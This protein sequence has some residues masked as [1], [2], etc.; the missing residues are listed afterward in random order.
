MNYGVIFAGGVGRRMQSGGIPKQFLTIDGIPIIVHTLQVFQD[1]NQID[2]INIAGLGGQ[3][4]DQLI[5]LVKQYNL[6][7]V[8]KIVTGGETGQMSIYNALMATK[9][10]SKTDKDIA[11]IHDGVRPIIDTKLLEENIENVKKYGTSISCV[12]QK[13]TT[14]LSSENDQIEGIT[15]RSKTYIARAPQSFYLN[16]ILEAEDLAIKN[17]ETNMIDSCSVMMK[18]GKYKNPHITP[19]NSDNIKITTPDDYYIA[20]ALIQSRKNKMILGFSDE[21]QTEDFER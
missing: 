19:C 5:S 21:K 10:I 11:L 1:C 13:E 3:Y 9:K 17:G 7:K 6:N 12:L 2:A 18:Y 20:N 16:D 8:S 15:N 4:L 14:V